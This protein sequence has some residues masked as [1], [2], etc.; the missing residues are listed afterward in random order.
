MFAVNIQ[1]HEAKRSFRPETIERLEALFHCAPVAYLTLTRN[2][3]IIDANYAAM[4]LV[5]I[6]AFLRPPQRF[7][8]YVKTSDLPIF[9]HHLRRCQVK[10]NGV[11]CSQL[12]LQRQGN[13]TL[14]ELR[15]LPLPNDDLIATAVIDRSETEKADQLLHAELE[16]AEH[17]IHAISYPLVVLDR[18]LRVQN[19][20]QSFVK[21]FRTDPNEVIGF[22]LAELQCVRWNGNSLQK[23][24]RDSFSSKDRPETFVAEGKLP[25]TGDEVH[26]LTTATP[27]EGRDGSSVLLL[28]SLRDVTKE[29][30]IERDGQAFLQQLASLNLRLEA[31][32][33]ERTA[34]LHAMSRKLITAQEEERRFLARELHDEIGQVLTQVKIHLEHQVPGGIE[35]NQVMPLIES[36]VDRVKQISLNL[37]PHMVDDLGLITAIKWHASEF[38]KRTKIRVS[39]ETSKFLEENLSSELKISLYRVAQESLTNVAKHSGAK[40]ASICLTTGH[41]SVTIRV[42]DRGKGFIPEA[43]EKPRSTGLSGMRERATLLGG[44]F[45]VKSKPGKGTQVIVNFPITHQAL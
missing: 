40:A 45:E 28:V 39:I 6:G 21:L 44:N 35:K 22:P 16:S 20:N 17:I 34:E 36:L 43:I 42:K 14:V 26:L 32:I 2:G 23:R 38:S 4:K 24:L 3:S 19:V 8:N 37:R 1:S 12:Y 30:K 5:G 13:R 18:K 27:V 31:R 7:T 15:S 11:I 33:K 10:S 41:D 29:Q 25:I 9:Q